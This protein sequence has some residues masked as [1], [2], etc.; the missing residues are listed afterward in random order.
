MENEE[1]YLLRKENKQLKEVNES[2][3]NRLKW[4]MEQLKEGLKILQ[5]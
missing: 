1:L 4:I 5:K 2:L 3:L